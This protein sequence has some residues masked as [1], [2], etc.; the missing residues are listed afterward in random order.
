MVF[1]FFKKKKESVFKEELFYNLKLMVIAT[2][3]VMIWR[4]IWNL[5][6]RYFLPEH[7]VMSNV[8]TIV[9]WILLIFI[10]EYDLETLWVWDEE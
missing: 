6:D 10:L 4:W 5:V 9:L 2:A 3:V 7:F 8:L 1:S